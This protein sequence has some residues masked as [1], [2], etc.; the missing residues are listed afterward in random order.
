[1]SN[2]TKNRIK[3][4]IAEPEKTNRWLVEKLERTKPQYQDGVRTEFN[5]HWIL[6]ELLLLL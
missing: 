1:M 4:V 6:K 2:A 3:I 5:Q